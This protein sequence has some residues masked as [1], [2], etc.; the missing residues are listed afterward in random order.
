M[1]VVLL[2]V[3]LFSIIDLK[4]GILFTAGTLMFMNNLS[5][6]IP[7][8]KLFYAVVLIQIVLFFFLGEYDKMKYPKLI[9]IPT[10]FASFCYIAS[11]YFG[12]I[13]DYAKNI[14][15][16]ST[17]F[18]FPYLV[19]HCICTKEDVLYFSRVLL[20]FFFVVA[21]YA[22]I[23]L[24]LGFN[25]YSEIANDTGMIAGELGGLESSE[26]FGLLRCNSILPYSSALG[27]N[28]SLVFVTTIILIAYHVKIHP[29]YFCLVFLLPFCVLLSG[30]RSQFVVFA[31]C[32]LAFL[33][34]RKYRNSS[35][36][37]VLV[38]LGFVSVL[39]L[40]PVLLEII[41]SII[42]SDSS[43]TQGSNLTMR[44][45][46]FAITESYWQQ[47]PW[48]GWGRNYTWNVAIPDNPALLG[49]ESI[50]FTQ[51]IDHGAFGLFCF[52]F[53]GICLA[54]Y[55][56]SFSMPLAILPIAFMLGKTMSTVV[57]VEYNIPIVLCVLA[58]K[59]ILIYKKRK[60]FQY[61]QLMLKIYEIKNKLSF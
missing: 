16:I 40:S 13:H 41:D 48:F 33:M 46:Q 54:V 3:I 9:L 30:T 56:Y 36:I 26:R 8:V 18:V 19:W 34:D 24:L 7:E 23:E 25:I 1:I 10:L 42:H 39:L 38:L 28:S 6:G 55:C 44:L 58:V 35:H 4:K 5:S 27:M 53:I 45:N 43:S 20:T 17:W 22:L 12:A 15:N 2:S 49:A 52:Y 37:K 61:L 32:F 59:T 60:R 57:G 11:S 31:T 50:I 29:Y 51:L 21:G 14:V 47:S